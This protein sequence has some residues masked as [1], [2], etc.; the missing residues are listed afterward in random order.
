LFFNITIVIV[1]DRMTAR[2]AI[3][4]TSIIE[5]SI[6]IIREGG[7]EAVSARSLAAKLGASTMPIYSTIGSMDELKAAS[8]ERAEAILLEWQLRPRGDNQALG[9]AVGYVSFA[10]EEPRLFHFTIGSRGSAASVG[11]TG[12]GSAEESV[13]F[14]E[15][16]GLGEV[17]SVKSVLD[18]FSDQGKRSDF[19]LRSW[20]FTHG[21]AELLAQGAFTMDDAEIRRHLLAAG[22]AMYRLEMER[23]Q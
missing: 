11:K 13:G 8:A 19:L 4:R 10:R 15:S 22:D 1:E 20:I 5:A 9:M 17:P 21:L 12:T 2:T 7:W 3:L 14:S 6:E 23:G 18:T 16:Q